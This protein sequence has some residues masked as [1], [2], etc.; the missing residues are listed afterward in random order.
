MHIKRVG[1][2]T[3]GCLLVLVTFVILDGRHKDQLNTI[4]SPLQSASNQLVATATGEEDNSQQLVPQVWLL[5]IAPGR[6]G[7]VCCSIQQ[8]NV[9][10]KQSFLTVANVHSTTLF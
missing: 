10:N 2:M 6:T 5:V 3:T 7:C 1:L 9:L 4:N 8:R